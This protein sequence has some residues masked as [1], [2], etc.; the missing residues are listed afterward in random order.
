MN[1]SASVGKRRAS[2]PL[3]GALSQLKLPLV[4][5]QWGGNLVLILLAMEW[6]RLP[7]LHFW[8]ILTAALWALGL[9]FLF[10]CL[11]VYTLRRLR[12]A[13]RPLPLPAAFLLAALWTG[14]WLLLLVP[15][16]VGEDRAGLFAGYLIFKLPLW[17]RHAVTFH[18]LVAWQHWIY[19]AARWL[20]A[21][22]LLPD[23]METVASG[24]HPDSFAR[25]SH[26][27]RR[28]F[29]WL[30][31]LFCGFS[32]SAITAASTE[33]MWANGTGEGLL[34]ASIRVGGAY[35]VDLLLWCFML[36]LVAFYLGEE[37]SQ[38]GGQQGRQTGATAP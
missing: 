9:V 17:L 11:Q 3:A 26:I 19:D 23:A 35:T 32:G 6:L 18:R 4:G 20:F 12:N 1:D 29:Y 22:L 7:S 33:W 36:G 31:A 13:A 38:Q 28:W 24:A 2:N 5:L 30:A 37:F 8:Q 27:Y 10:L 16:G 21:G 14:V 25:A 34:R 15:I